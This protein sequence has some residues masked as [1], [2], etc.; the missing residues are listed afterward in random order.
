[1]TSE[2]YLPLMAL[3]PSIV[4]G[5]VNGY[6]KMAAF[7]D[8]DENFMVYRRFGYM[9]SRILLARQEK[10]RRLEARLQE[11]DEKQ[12]AE[13]NQPKLLC[14]A[15]IGGDME[16]VRESLMLEIENEYLQYSTFG[17][18]FA[19]PAATDVFSHAFAE[20]AGDGCSEQA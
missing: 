12:V 10:L 11:L 20:R 4:H 14:K 16:V 1:M 9:Q 13:S 19:K 3:T 8:S 5:G 2:N 6:P 15:R 18:C 17:N 7:L